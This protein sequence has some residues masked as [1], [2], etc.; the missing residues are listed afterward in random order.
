MTNKPKKDDTISIFSKNTEIEKMK[1]RIVKQTNVIINAKYEKLHNQ[2]EGKLCHFMV[3]EIRKKYEG[4]WKVG[5]NTES[6][7]VIILAKEYSKIMNIDLK[8]VYRKALEIAKG[9]MSKP[10]QIETATGWELFSWITGAVYDDGLLTMDIHPKIIPHVLDLP[11]RYFTMYEEGNIAKLRSHYAIRL[12]D[13]FRSDAFRY[14]KEMTIN[15]L[16]ECLALTEKST[17]RSAHVIKTKILDSS[18]KEINENTDIVVKYEDACK[19]RKL[20]T[21]LKFTIVLKEK[22]KYLEKYKKEDKKTIHKIDVQK[23]TLPPP[24]WNVLKKAQQTISPS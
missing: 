11:D 7:T 1:N 18:L 8:N 17:Y 20:V 3:T 23:K 14:T 24:N 22:I 4:K 16:I 15:E 13:L 6:I 5:D 12:Y 9:I 19:I 2:Y 10:L 21:S